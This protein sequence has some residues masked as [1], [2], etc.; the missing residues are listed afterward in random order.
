MPD[1]ITA[2]KTPD[3]MTRVE[4]AKPEDH[5]V[6]GPILKAIQSGVEAYRQRPDVHAA[7]TGATPEEAAAAQ[8]QPEWYKGL[9]DETK[10]YNQ[11][12]AHFREGM[13]RMTED[14]H[15]Y[16]EMHRG[17][18]TPAAYLMLHGVASAAE[19]V[20]I[21]RTA[22]DTAASI[23]GP[24]ELG[25][26][27]GLAREMGIEYRGIQQGI[28]GK[29]PDLLIFQDPKSGTSI[30]VK[31]NEFTP[32]KLE[33]H[34]NAARERMK[35]KPTVQQ[36]V[37]AG[38]TGAMSSEELSRPDVF[39]KFSKSGQPEYLG[40]K[41]DATLKP[42]E[43][44]L[45]VNKQT[46]AVRTQ[47]TNGLA[48]KEALERFGDRAKNFRQDI[49]NTE[50][51]SDPD[52][53]FNAAQHEAGHIVVSEL[54]RP[55]SVSN[56]SL[57]E[58]GGFTHIEPPAGKANPKDLTPDE[59]KNLVAVSY[60][61]GLNEQGGTTKQHVSADQARREQVLGPQGL[62]A[63][64]DMAGARARINAL[65]ADK[66]TQQAIDRVAKALNE[67]GKLTGDEIRKIIGG[68]K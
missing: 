35:P 14:L 27:H 8:Q 15:D 52:T 25:D 53:R 20:P 56:S 32:E 44:I 36:T 33:S 45:A 2:T 50:S 51:M 29:V 10:W 68:S 17:V 47:N 60:A 1:T 16:A 12:F 39:I 46:G 67:K 41:P 61:G 19:Q 23:F 64:E 54:L 57:D 3:W 9:V 22:T 55:G 42:G 62:A 49:E 30:G 38:G 4:Q 26:M 7:E 28:P 21:S 65:L 40:K 18:L 13:D 63:N 58:H 31:R 37:S 59:V 6:F 5:P 24:P 11:P 66:N 43:A 34:V 48:D